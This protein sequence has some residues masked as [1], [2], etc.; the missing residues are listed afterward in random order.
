VIVYH[1]GVSGNHPWSILAKTKLSML[2]SFASLYRNDNHTQRLVELANDER[3]LHHFVDSGAFTLN[4]WLKQKCG[5]VENLWDSEEHW[6]YV[7]AYIDWLKSGKVK[8][9]TYANVDRIGDSETSHRNL[10][11]ME[12]KGTRP[13]PV[14]HYPGSFE[15]LQRYADSYEYIGLGGMVGVDRKTMIGWLDRCFEILCPPPRYVCKVK[16]HGFGISGFSI[17]FRYPWYSVDS[18]TYALLGGY[19]SILVPCMRR[20]RFVFDMPPKTIPISIRRGGRVHYEFL[21]LKEKNIICDWVK[22]C[23]LSIQEVLEGSTERKIVNICYLNSVG[24]VLQYDRPFYPSVKVGM[25]W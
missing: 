13:I 7:D 4:R 6:K 19:G 14:I 5:D 20:G 3:V 17:L 11:Y 23:G 25:L 2:T 10:V 12:E 8:V 22:M 9:D 16:V 21:S 15:W 24:E 1:G 18:V